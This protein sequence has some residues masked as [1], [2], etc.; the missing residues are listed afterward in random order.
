MASVINRRTQW[1]TVILLSFALFLAGCP[2]NKAKDLL[3]TAELEERQMNVVHA[4]QLYEEVIRLYPESK[5][6][7]SARARLAALTHE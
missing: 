2:G 7:E 3:E 1:Q 6:A 4:K 5:E